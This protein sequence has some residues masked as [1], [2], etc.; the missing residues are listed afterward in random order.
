MKEVS[1]IIPLYNAEKTIKVCLDSITKEIDYSKMEVIIIDDGSDDNSSQIAQKYSNIKIL[2]K[3][4]GGVSSARNLGLTVAEGKYVM[5]VDADDCMEAGWYTKVIECLK[6]ND[7]IY[8]FSKKY[9]FEF[10]KKKAIEGI[11]IGENDYVYISSV[12]SKIYKREII[13]NNNITFNENIINGEDAI[14]NLN[15]I[16]LARN[17]KMKCDSIYKYRVSK[18]SY[19]KRFDPRIFSSDEEFYRSIDKSLRNIE[20]INKK[21]LTQKCRSNNLY[22]IALRIAYEKNIRTYKKYEDEIEKYIKYCKID[23][24]K[25]LRNIILWLIKNKLYVMVYI[26]FRVKIF[27]NFGKNYRFI[28]I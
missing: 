14:F 19:T 10:D 5:F 15:L 13:N 4:N 3:K 26:F 16:C 18:M 12:W 7:D 21:L 28:T 2:N 24:G 8:M 11:F 25:K 20:G 6:S 23:N 22:M 1:I 27:Y 9:N 17:V